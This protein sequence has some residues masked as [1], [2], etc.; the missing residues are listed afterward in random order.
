MGHE[1]MET[2]CN[3]NKAF[4]PGTASECPVHGWFRKFRKGDESLKDEGHHDWPAKTDTDQR[5]A[6]IEAG[7][8]TTTQ[9]GAQEL[10]V[11]RSMDIWHLKK[12]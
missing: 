1:T 5:R 8:L 2:T 3:I 12:K 4:G 6:V 9:E 7:L 10:N 11:D